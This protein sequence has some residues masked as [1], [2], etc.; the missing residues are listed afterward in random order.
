VQVGE[1]C[2]PPLAAG[3][4]SEPRSTRSAPSCSA[5]QTGACRGLHRRS[6]RQ[7]TSDHYVTS[8]D[9]IALGLGLG[10]VHGERRDVQGPLTKRKLEVAAL[11]E[12]GLSNR[13]IAERLVV[14]KRTA[15]GH[16][17][18]ILAKLGFTS[19]SQVAAWMSRERAL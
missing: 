8:T 7:P 1:G 16:V 19:R 12:A 14:A 3:G 5:G 18:R 10:S 2:A 17:E 13:A 6:S 11:I 15:D 9:V 4:R